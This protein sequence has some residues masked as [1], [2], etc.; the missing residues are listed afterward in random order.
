MKFRSLSRSLARFSLFL[1]LISAVGLVGLNNGLDP[2]QV[3]RTQA[4]NIVIEL[5]S[6]GNSQLTFGISA[7]C[8][9]TAMAPSDECLANVV[10]QNTGDTPYTLT[11]P[12]IAVSGPLSSCG[13]GGWFTASLGPL[14]Y[15]PNL[16]VFDVGDMHNF[17]V[18]SAL[19]FNTPNDCQGLTGL[20][21]ITLVATSIDEEE[22]PF[23]PTATA[24]PTATG[25]LSPTPTFTFTPV[26]QTAGTRATA[27]PTSTPRPAATFTSQV[28]PSRFPSTGQG[29]IAGDSTGLIR[30]VFMGIGLVAIGLFIT[31]LT[32][33]SREQSDDE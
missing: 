8:V 19:D 15:T 29:G 5:T 22:E 28:L 4:A 13:G 18:N 31:A 27:V 14:T 24:T 10:V 2:R 21:V 17:D 3:S 12:S 26:V 9:P 11:E 6:S 32:L 30:T 1:F 16:T 25:T 23:T 33:R 7:N 20:I